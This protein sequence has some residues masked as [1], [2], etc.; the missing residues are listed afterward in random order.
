MNDQPC[1]PD[2]STPPDPP[3]DPGAALNLTREAASRVAAFDSS[4]SRLATGLWG[5]VWLFGYGALWFGARTTGR[6]PAWAFIVFFGL[7]ITGYVICAVV[8]SR[9]GGDVVGPSALAGAL[10]GWSWMVAFGVGMSTAGIIVSNYG[11]SDQAT[12]VLFNA[13]TAI[14]AGTL[15]MAGGAIFK[16]PAMFAFGAVLGVLAPV[17]ALIGV[18]A[19]Y[20][21]MALVGG[22]LLLVTYAILTVQAHAGRRPK[23]RATEQGR[24]A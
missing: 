18:P 11:L 4:I 13:M 21:L 5:V 2:A 10:Y 7:V 6:P 24:P 23:R 19:G 22:G 9:R 15:F 1:E 8:G 20:L 17:S 3:L 12:G 14:L 16:E